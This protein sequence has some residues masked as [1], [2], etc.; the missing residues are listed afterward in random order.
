MAY[1]LRFLIHIVSFVV[2][3]RIVPGIRSENW[4]TTII[5]AIVFGLINIFIKPIVVGITF[6]LTLLTFGIFI[7]FINAFMFW[8]V[9][10][11]VPGFTINDFLSAFLGS[12]LFCL[13]SFILNLLIQPND[14]FRIQFYSTKHRSKKNQPIDVEFKVEEEEHNP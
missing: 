5:A 10:R 3:L 6:P 7:F 14:R 8:L 2:V 9:A 4:E 13:V 12:L 11:F 1:I